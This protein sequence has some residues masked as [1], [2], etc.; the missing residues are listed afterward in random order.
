LG[1]LTACDRFDVM[2]RLGEIDAPALVVAGS[3]DRLA[4]VKYAH[5]LAAHVS[6][7]QIAIVEGAGHMVML[8]RSAEVAGSIQRFLAV[9]QVG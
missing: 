4:P 1:D 5:Y 7:A 2:E 8:E 9:G 3:A 6:G